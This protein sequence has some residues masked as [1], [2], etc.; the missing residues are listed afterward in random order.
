MELILEEDIPWQVAFSPTT[1]RKGPPSGEVCGDDVKCLTAGAEAGS[2][3]PLLDR[4]PRSSDG[5]FPVGF[6]GSIYSFRHKYG[7]RLERWVRDKAWQLFK[8]WSRPRLRQW[9]I[10]QYGYLDGYLDG[11]GFSCPI[12]S[13]TNVLSTVIASHTVDIE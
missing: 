2:P 3:G 11:Y 4:W 8:Q 5:E 10:H 9:S 7:K 6:P 12:A 13:H 1:A